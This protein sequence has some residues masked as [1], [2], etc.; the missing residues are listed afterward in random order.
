[1]NAVAQTSRESYQDLQALAFNDQHRKLLAAMTP[2]QRYTRRE[3]ATFT[4][5]ETAS[6]SARCN[7]L[8]K[9]SRI[10]VIGRKVD[11]YTGRFVEALVR[12]V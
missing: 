8:L 1:V 3:L 12:F 9:D 10:A 11:P 7:E 4:G 6:V 2:H 5:I